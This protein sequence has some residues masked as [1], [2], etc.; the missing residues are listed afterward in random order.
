MARH[1]D[2]NAAAAPGQ[3]DQVGGK[4]AERTSERIHE[5]DST[6]QL[7]SPKRPNNGALPTSVVHPR[8]GSDAVPSGLDDLVEC[9]AAFQFS[10][11]APRA[12]RSRPL[13]GF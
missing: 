6:C 9:G 7:N 2:E 4:T 3:V 8:T 11:F 10:G 12:L 5:D 1:H 13:R